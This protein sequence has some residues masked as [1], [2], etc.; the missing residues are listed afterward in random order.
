MNTEEFKQWVPVLQPA[1][2]RMAERFLDSK[3]EAK[4]VVQDLFVELWQNRHRLDG[5]EN[6]QGYCVRMTQFHCIDHLKAMR[7]QTTSITQHEE[8]LADIPSDSEEREQLFAELQRHLDG[9]SE[10]D[11]QLLRLHYWDNLSSREIGGRL[12]IS[13]GNV[14]V[15]LTRIV[16]KLRG[17]MKYT[18]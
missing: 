2:Q 15:R 11:Q 3:Q 4:D 12:R 7:L 5:V 18:K 13:E 17:K 10:E 6:L 16:Q 1:M 14:R 9:L 8:G